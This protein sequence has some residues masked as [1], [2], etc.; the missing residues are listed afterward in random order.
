MTDSS[1]QSGFYITGCESEM[2]KK[3]VNLGIS[4]FRLSDSTLQKDWAI[5]ESNKLGQ[6]FCVAVTAHQGWDNNPETEIPYAIA[7]SF[8]S[9]NKDVEVYESIRVEN[10]VE[11]REE[12]RV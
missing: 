6:E 11:I 7:V 12:V 10:E 8:E 2:S 5:V 9:I 4:T 3:Q 1:L